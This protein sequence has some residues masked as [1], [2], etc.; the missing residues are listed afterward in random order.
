MVPA[1]AAATNPARGNSLRL[2]VN[3]SMEDD[4]FAEQLP[5]DIFM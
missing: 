1:I 3:V 5:H 4:I 2:I